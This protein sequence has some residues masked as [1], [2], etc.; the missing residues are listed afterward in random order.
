M[1]QR[2]AQATTEE[3]I[4]EGEATIPH[5]DVSV[6]DFPT[7]TRLRPKLSIDRSDEEFEEALEQLLTRIEALVSQ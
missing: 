7:I 1:T 4:D 5:S 6:K 2:G 3:V